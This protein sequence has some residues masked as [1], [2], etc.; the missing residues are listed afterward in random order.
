MTT[1][2]KSAGT[3]PPQPRQAQSPPGFTEELN[4]KPDHGEHSYRGCGKL[5][6]RVALITGADSGIGRAVA[7]AF[8]REGADVVVSYLCEDQEARETAHWVEKSGRRAVTIAGD[9]A[10][11][12]HCREL[13]NQALQSFGRLDILVNNA[14][15]QATHQSIEEIT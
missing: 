7:I 4:P 14:A 6:G 13:V 5:K 3:T 2:P 11:S 8:A 1:D 9:V 12:T 15:F 10:D